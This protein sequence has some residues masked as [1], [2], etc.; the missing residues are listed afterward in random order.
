MPKWKKDAKQFRVKVNSHPTR[1]YQMNIPK[2]I[3][4]HLGKGEEVEA[5][6]YAIRKGRVELRL[7]TTEDWAK[8]TSKGRD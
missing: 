6:E 5:L 7:P 1:G 3:I 4:E 8:E 2:P